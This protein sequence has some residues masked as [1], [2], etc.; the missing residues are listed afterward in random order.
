MAGNSIGKLFR[1][2]TFGE[3]HGGCVGCVVDGCPAGLEISE[4]D[5]QPDL[6]RRRPGQSNLSTPRKETDKITIYSGVFEGKTTGTPIM[7]YAKNEDPRPQDYDQMNELYRPSH[8]DYTYDEKYGNRD[9]R[10]GGRSSARTTLGVVAAG[11]L[12]KKL[13][14]EKGIEILGYVEQVGNLK[15][16]ID[17]KKVTLKDVEATDTRCPDPE[18]AQQMTDLI[19]ETKRQ[20]DS[21]GGV[22]FCSIKGLPVGLG[23]PLF[24]KLNSDL[25]KAMMTINAT[26]GFEMGSGFAGSKMK[27][28][29]HNDEFYMEGDRVRTKTNYSGGTLGG[30]SNG[31]DVY[32]RTAFKPVAT[33]MQK[34]NTVTRDHEEVEFRAIGRHDP[35]VVTRA[36][37]IVEAMAAITMMDHYLRMKAYE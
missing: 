30:I 18:L 32:F 5:I 20:G 10:G 6:D 19:L 9:H 29:E 24:D 7:M 26:K 1:V 33:I 13:L 2:T 17:Y 25:A 28:S 31:E 8:A 16:D 15:T 34:Q 23:Q 27:G 3:S 14:K 22:V 4:K 11:A 21:L 35:C 37:V 36:V 12:A